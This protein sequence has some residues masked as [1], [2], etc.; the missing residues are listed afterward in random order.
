MNKHH[1]SFIPALMII[2]AAGCILPM[3]SSASAVHTPQPGNPER[4][5]ILDAVRPSVQEL[6]G[7]RDIVFVV[8]ELHVSEGWAWFRGR[9]QSRGGDARFEDIS[10]LIRR[11]DARAN[12]WRLVRILGIEPGEVDDPE[13]AEA[14]MWTRLKLEFPD[15]PQALVDAAHA[16]A[17]RRDG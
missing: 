16:A 2:L 5:A 14:Q 13:P 3:V 7:R 15:L 10:A 1:R 12:E 17:S 8:D 4:K 6:T 11:V 9:P